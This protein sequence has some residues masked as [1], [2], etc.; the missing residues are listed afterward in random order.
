M[1]PGFA[2]LMRGHLQNQCNVARH[3]TQGLLSTL[4]ADATASELRGSAFGL[5]NLACGGAL[6][7]ASFIAGILWQEVGP[8]ATFVVGAALTSAGL[9]ASAILTVRGPA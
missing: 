2:D 3:M 7:P 9:L 8:F 4:V 1:L 5:F 6:L